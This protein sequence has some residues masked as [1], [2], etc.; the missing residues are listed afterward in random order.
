MNDAVDLKQL[1]IRESEQVEWKENVSEIDDVVETLSAFA[2]D[3]ANLGGGYVVCGAR[4]DKDSHGFPVLVRVGLTSSRFKEVENQVLARC[5]SHVSPPIAPQVLEQPSDVDGSR[6]LIFVQAAT[7]QAHT[8]R[9]NKE[10]AKH[11]VRISRSTIE[12]RNGVL[13]NLLVRK[14]ALEPWDR[15]VCNGATVNDLDLLSL[16]E[17]LLRMG[18]FSAER[19]VEP[20]LL[21]EAQLSPLVPALCIRDLLTGVVRPRNFA[22]LLFGRETQRFV[23]GAVS[24]FS[25]YP[26][27]D[28]SDSH[29]ERH[30]LP[31]NLL[32]QARKL[33]ELLD[34]QSYTAFDKNDPAVPNAVKYPKRALYEA[35]GNALA[36][37]DYESLDPTRITVFSDRIEILSPGPLP[38]GVDPVAFREGR[39]P[40]KWRNQALAW[41]FVRLQLG[42]GEGQG[43]P[44]ILRVM[45]DEGCPPPRLTADDNFVQ[46]VLPAHPRHA[47]LRDLRAVEQA[48]AIGDEHKA[49]ELVG[50]VL[51][52]DPLNSRALQL[53]AEVHHAL[54]DPGPIAQ[55][56]VQ[57]AAHVDSLPASVLVQLAEALVASDTA[58]ESKKILSNKLLAS[59]SRGRLEERELRRIALAMV[60]GHEEP[61]ALALLEK[62]LLEH[63]EWKRSA[64]LLQLRGDAL[65]GLAKRCRFTA[66]KRDI[67]P[68]TQQRS[69]REFHAYLAD[70]ERELQDARALSVD[71]H[72]TDQIRVNLDYIEQLRRENPAQSGG[73]R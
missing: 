18:V 64:S 13:L 58:P 17:A 39:S 68:Q 29:A 24:L 54:R 35:M 11:S 31:G 45:R 30:E 5:R 59:A 12:A 53:F 63:P 47:L 67:A 34:V 55:H 57:H 62:H 20:Y 22:M 61:A 36:H 41:F 66:K 19:G 73:R 43:I 69:W 16:R 7:N 1:S 28:R 37:R 38:L 26:G 51:S 9:R 27:I 25:I 21:P 15:R 8:F 71:Q 6:I 40:S 33:T 4:E 56:L 44:T 60:R 46:C 42:Q 10:G 52:R 3:F 70:A 49:Q 50:Q 23:P 72:L 2:N 32:S 48:L 14:G 65:I